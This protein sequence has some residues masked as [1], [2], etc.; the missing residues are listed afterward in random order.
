MMNITKKGILIGLALLLALSFSLVAAVPA[1][2]SPGT[3]Q[4]NVNDPSC[5]MGSGQPDPYSVVYCSIQDAIDDANLAGGD[6][7]IVAAGTYD[8][9]VIIDKALTLQGAGDTTIIKPSQTT[10]DNF[11]L[12]ERKATGSGNDSAPI[13]VATTSGD[14]VNI[15]DLKIDGSLVGFVPGG[16]SMFAGILYRDTSGLVDSVT[17]DN[18]GITNGCGMYMVGHDTA[19]QV[20][21]N[22]CEISGYLKNGITTN[23]PNMTS[24]IHNNT[25]TGMGPT[26]SIAQNGIQIGFEASG[27]ISNNNV[28]GHVWTGTYGGSN[29]PANDPDADGACGILLYH[30]GNT[31]IEI[32]GNTLTGNQFGIWSVG[33]ISINVHDNNITGLA[34]TGNAYPT[35]IAVWDT[36]MWGDDFG[37][38]E[39][40]TTGT[41]SWNTFTTHD[42]GILVHD[43]AVG[44]ALPVVTVTR[45]DFSNNDIQLIDTGETL[46]IQDILDTNNFDR[47]VVTDRP[48]SSLL[49]VIWSNIQDAIDTAISGDTIIVAPGTYHEE[50]TIDVVNL[51]LKAEPKW[52]AIIM[53]TTTPAN[54][55]AAI[56]ISADDVT[57][58]GFEI[59][60]TT[61]CNNGIYGWETSGLTIK[62]NKIHGAVHD[63]D[64]CG[65]LLI[66]WGNSST[67]YN[68]LIENNLIYDTGRNT[69]HDAWMV[70]WGDG[71]GGIQINVGKDCAITN[72]EVYNVQ[73]NQRGIYM[74]GSAAGNT[75]TNNT[76]R[77]NYVGIQL[78]IS[79][80]GGTTIEW[81]SE[82]PTSPQVHC[83]NIYNNSYYGAISTNIQGTPIKM[84]AENNWWGCKDGPGNPGCDAVSDYVVF[85]PWLTGLWQV[86]PPCGTPPP[87]PLPS[88]PPPPGGPVGITVVPVDK[89]GL[90]LPWTALA[91]LLVLGIGAGLVIRRRISR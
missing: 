47:C 91:G 37:Y 75:I 33:A 14:T 35:G 45:N 61:V 23:F 1:S 54:H 10:A 29:D 59:D 8:E 13:V 24:N 56:Y 7:I 73:N 26:A 74:F 55:G 64:G 20:E 11:Q 18:I 86:T 9:Q 34:H 72:N 76:I 50:I 46:D 21:I 31:S 5:V 90:L 71:G 66:S 30:P 89:A 15:Q 39:V 87:P 80:E 44:G 41:I 62:N 81:G 68:N 27:T 65:I 28:S 42:Y 79:G 43:Y 16:A 19:V 25:M 60:G 57:V 22:S 58:D 53:P 70:T 4:V 82:N 84:D 88:P 36:D 17:I 78:W 85:T 12:F 38:T 2:A 69:V 40:G 52:G 67:V 49:Y 3:I 6:T 51:T 83:N 63:W 77:D 48:G 32:A